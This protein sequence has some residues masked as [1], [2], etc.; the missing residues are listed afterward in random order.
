MFFVMRTIKHSNSSLSCSKIVTVAKTCYQTTA[1][2]DGVDLRVARW[3]KAGVSVQT[4]DACTSMKTRVRL[5][6][7]DF[8]LTPHTCETFKRKDTGIQD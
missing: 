7:V 6:V 1:S 2:V 5:T 8:N 4:I 3:T